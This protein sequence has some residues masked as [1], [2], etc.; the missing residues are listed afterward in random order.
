[1]RKFFA[2]PAVPVV[3]RILLGAIFVYAGFVSIRSPE[4]FSDSVAAYQLLPAS[5]INLLALALPPFEMLAGALLIA[6]AWRR[7]ATLSALVLTVV[8]AIALS[9]A[10]ARGLT[11]DCGCFGHGAPSRMKMWISLG[12]DLLLGA[13]LALLYRREHRADCPP[14]PSDAPG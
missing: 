9:S 8:F 6:G 13:A 4:E 7:V 10:I 1:M 3:A 2:N 11:I 12:R 14:S 5:A